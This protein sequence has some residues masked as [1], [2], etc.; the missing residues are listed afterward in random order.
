M[1]DRRSAIV[2]LLLLIALG[3]SSCTL[4]KEP[5]TPGW[6]G[7]TA[8]EDHERLMWKSIQSG[9]WQQVHA[10]MAPS[11]VGVTSAGVRD[12]AATLEHLK[13]MKIEEFS[14]GEFESTPHGVD[15]AAT[16]LITLRGTVAGQPLPAEP[17]RVIT[18]WQT[19][20]GGWI[21][22]AQAVM[23]AQSTSH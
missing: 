8:I 11:F 20:K 10:H 4:W 7:V 19:V 5:K 1:P 17:M 16:Y 3:L 2:C 23:P 21:E 15:M 14:L 12:R 9:D 6:K 22:I 18:V 13:Q